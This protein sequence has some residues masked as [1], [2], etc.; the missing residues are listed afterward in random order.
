MQSLTVDKS[1]LAL[2]LPG[3][4]DFLSGASSERMAGSSSRSSGDGS[5]KVDWPALLPLMLSTIATAAAAAAPEHSWNLLKGCLKL[6][7]ACAGAAEQHTALHAGLVQQRLGPL[8][9]QLGPAVVAAC[10]AAEP[11]EQA[12]RERADSADMGRAAVMSDFSMPEEGL[13]G[14]RFFY[15][16]DQPGVCW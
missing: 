2:H 4:F 13:H 7:G 9:H 16:T 1:R 8:L 6:C 10:S 12:D 15:T 5:G 11:E 3:S 14:V